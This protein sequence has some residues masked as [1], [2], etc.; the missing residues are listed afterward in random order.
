[1]A[2]RGDLR[3]ALPGGCKCNIEMHGVCVQ[4]L[5]HHITSAL[6][7]LHAADIVHRDIKPANLL[8]TETDSH[9]PEMIQHC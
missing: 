8:I 1:M 4:T 2:E 7:V 3:L 5:F 6:D 9:G